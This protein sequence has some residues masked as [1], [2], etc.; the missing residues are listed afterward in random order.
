MCGMSMCERAGAHRCLCGCV[1]ESAR[2]KIK[3]G[4]GDV[5]ALSS[6]G[7]CSILHMLER[8]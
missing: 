6:G 3:Q 5:G 1:V 8:W 4:A 2:E 7:C